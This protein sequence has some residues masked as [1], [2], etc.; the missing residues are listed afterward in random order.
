ML[1]VANLG[2]QNCADPIRNSYFISN[3]LCICILLGAR[4]TEGIAK[5]NLLFDYNWNVV[6]LQIG[7]LSIAHSVLNC[8]FS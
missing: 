1:L 7:A 4:E 2:L 3:E 5:Q 8:S 6:S